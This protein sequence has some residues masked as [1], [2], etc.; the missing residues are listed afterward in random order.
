MANRHNFFLTIFGHFFIS[1]S[2]LIF[3][4]KK[5]RLLAL[6]IVTHSLGNTIYSCID[7]RCSMLKF[8]SEMQR[9]TSINGEKVILIK[10]QLQ[11]QR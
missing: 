6:D 3:Q 1:E 10:I 11:V 9:Y 4:T 5:L 8:A 7:Q 2:F